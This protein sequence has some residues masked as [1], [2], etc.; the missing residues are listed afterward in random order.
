M[1]A[2][3]IAASAMTACLALGA[4]AQGGAPVTRSE[5]APSATA[6]PGVT[7]PEKPALPAPTRPATPTP[8][9]GPTPSPPT[10]ITGTVSA[11]VEPG[12][13]LLDGYLLVGGPPDLLRPGVRVTVTGRAQPD[14]ITTCQQGTPFL[15][16]T[17][18]RS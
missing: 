14:L 11:G 3:R 15:V 9:P 13:L 4:C 10:R 18:S 12:C 7:S 16:E 6:Q 8:P 17:A 5:G 2:T 1:N